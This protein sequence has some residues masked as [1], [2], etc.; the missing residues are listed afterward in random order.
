MHL[1][2][3]KTGEV[4]SRGRKND[5]I[6]TEGEHR[7]ALAVQRSPYDNRW[8]S[9]VEA[10]GQLTTAGEATGRVDVHLFNRRGDGWSAST[11]CGPSV[12]SAGR[13]RAR[14]QT[15]SHFSFRPRPSD[16]VET[17]NRDVFPADAVPGLHETLQGHVRP[18]GHDSL[19]DLLGGRFRGND[20]ACPIRHL[21]ISRS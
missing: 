12:R 17:G 5:G 19:Q 9:R 7:R 14:T 1:L 15:A 10:A 11:D 13:P 20:A 16:A 21:Q 4:V 18:P 3:R 6:R 2:R 8:S